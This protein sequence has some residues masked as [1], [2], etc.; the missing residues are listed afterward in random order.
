[1]NPISLEGKVAVVTEGAGGIG[2]GIAESFVQLGARVI[3]P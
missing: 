1:M 2:R 3:E